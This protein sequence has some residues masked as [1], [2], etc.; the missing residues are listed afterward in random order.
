MPFGGVHEKSI[1]ER[2]GLCGPAATPMS[3]EVIRWSKTMK[4]IEP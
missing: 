2:P 4:R 3:R 1:D